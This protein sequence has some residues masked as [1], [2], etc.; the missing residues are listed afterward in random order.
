LEA[1]EFHYKFVI[2]P[3]SRTSLRATASQAT[4][5]DITTGIML[6][7]F[8]SGFADISLPELILIAAMAMIASVVGGVAGYGTGALLPL[9]LVPIMGAEPVV[10]ILS[11]SALFT[12]SSRAAAFWRLVDRRRAV[13]ALV[14]AVPTCALGAWGYTLLTGR[15]AALV[16]GAMLIASV[17]LRRLMRRK[18]L[19][20]SSRGLAVACFGWGPLAGGTVGAGI[21]L[22]SLLMAAGL[23]GAAVV[24]TD[25]VI[26][27]GIGMT[28]LATFGLAGAVTAKVIAVALLIGAVA[29][30]GAFVAKA[31]TERLPM[32]VHTA[33]LDA[34]VVGG[35]AAMIVNAFVR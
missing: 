34:M 9:V 27:I 18:G 16:I 35:G 19:A 2:H 12:N 25:A 33:I 4:A 14:A 5:A 21:I 28:K 6:E 31:L 1:L 11:L 26:S 3:K 23:E 32:H 10:P 30:P 29:F 7:S 8:F 22:L 17:P 15:G 13:I 20:L 24:A